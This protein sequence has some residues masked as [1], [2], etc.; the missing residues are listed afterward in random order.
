MAYQSY[1]VLLRS[2]KRGT[3]LHLSVDNG[4]KLLYFNTNERKR[5]RSGS[6]IVKD[7]WLFE[8]TNKL[9]KEHQ[10]E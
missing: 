4:G 8:A 7:Q 5:S 9:V 6:F 2:N 1:E 3:T 10:T